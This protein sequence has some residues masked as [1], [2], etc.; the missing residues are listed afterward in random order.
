MFYLAVSI[1]KLSPQHGTPYAIVLFSKQANK[2]SKAK[3]NI[4]RLCLLVYGPLSPVV[5]GYLLLIRPA[6]DD[7]NEIIKALNKL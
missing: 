2:D 5:Q 6:K 4:T 1:Q 3:Q 7:S